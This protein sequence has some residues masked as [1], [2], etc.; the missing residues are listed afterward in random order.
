[1][2]QT[3]EKVIRGYYDKMIKLKTWPMSRLI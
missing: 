3:G 2:I 1:M